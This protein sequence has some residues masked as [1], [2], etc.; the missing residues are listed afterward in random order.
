MA[1]RPTT[2]DW[3]GPLLMLTCF[4]GA[5]VLATG[6]HIF[7][8]Y[9]DGVPVAQFALGQQR[10]SRVENATAYVVKLL[11]VLTTSTAYFQSV[12][13]HARC[14]P[15]KIGQFDTMFGALDNI[16]ELGHLGFWLRRPVLVASVMI[17]WLIPLIAIVT[18]G[19]L[20]VRSASVSEPQTI[21]VQQ[22]EYGRSLYGAAVQA[23]NGTVF[24]GGARS[25]LKGPTLATF[26][27]TE[28]L[29][30][31]RVSTNL[32]Y[33]MD[34]FGPAL[35]CT[36]A[37]QQVTAQSAETI[38]QFEQVNQTSLV[39]DVWIP[40]PN[41][42][43]NATLVDGD[44][45]LDSDDNRKLRILDQTSPDAAKIYYSLESLD[46]GTGTGTDQ[47]TGA[48]SSSL[49]V[50]Q[51]A[52]YNAS[53]NVAFDVRQTGEQ[54]LT[55]SLSFV[56][57]MPGWSSI[58]TPPLTAGSTHTN[59][60]LDYAGLLET[61][62]SITSGQMKVPDDENLPFTQTSLALEISP[63]FFADVM[64]PTTTATPTT[65]FEQEAMIRLQRTLE[66][67]FENMTLSAR[68][69]V[70]PAQDLRGDTALL[71]T[72]QVNAT[73]TFSR[74]VYR[75]DARGLV[76]AYALAIVGSAACLVV[77][78]LAVRDMRAVYANNF[79]TVVRV[80][81]GQRRCLDQVI[82]DEGDRSGAEPLPKRVAD[83]YIWVGRE[84]GEVGMGMGMGKQEGRVG[85]RMRMR[86]RT[87]DG[88]HR[89][90][91]TSK[92]RGL[93]SKK[94]G[95]MF[96]LRKGKETDVAM[97]MDREKQS[98]VDVAVREMDVRWQG[99]WI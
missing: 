79:S 61:F 3:R 34:F 45:I 35:S 65:A 52:L 24:Y 42:T 57:W 46:G 97:D 90:R 8:S 60:I 56:D 62:G 81:S 66:V 28:I 54:T 87:G 80:A 92:V 16:F 77:A 85:M 31:G 67:L 58:T 93:G 41:A 29:S 26:A 83:A 2:I 7:N 71:S 20:S 84:E 36:K 64:P 86:M 68:Y 21:S 19:T 32:T 1:H 11:L 33:P 14:R 69:A 48:S 94:E 12:W 76:V 73:S 55:P 10:V 59:S 40:K 99:N 13:H 39:Y 23:D 89:S 27:E 43:S 88:G 18:P 98:Q 51:C 63:V 70:L 82:V 44:L 15:T 49:Y 72:V 25:Y 96:W 6:H 9:L 38:S 74:N 30:V 95:N 5:V 50:I 17:V 4:V 91:C 47:Q 22:R 78:M 37:G 53:W 75:Y